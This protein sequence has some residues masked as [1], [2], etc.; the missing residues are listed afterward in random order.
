MAP[1]KKVGIPHHLKCCVAPK[2]TENLSAQEEIGAGGFTRELWINESAK[3]ADFKYPLN[4]TST[5][6]YT[7]L[8]FFPKGLYE[9]F[10]RLANLYFLF[11][12]A[13]SLTP[14]TPYSPVTVILP[15]LFVIGVSLIK[16]AVRL[17]SYLI[18]TSSAP[19]ID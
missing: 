7:L 8:S 4:R 9:Q 14:L 13:I 12:A 1:I 3:N 11:S 2:T 6:K 10:R 15:L 5:T 17:V 19:V 16:E 18:A